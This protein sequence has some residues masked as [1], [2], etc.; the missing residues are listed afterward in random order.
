MDGDIVL[1]AEA[2]VEPDQLAHFIGDGHE[3]H[4]LYTF[5]LGSYLF[6]ALSRESGAPVKKPWELLPDKPEVGQWVNFRRNLDELDLERT[7]DRE[8][9][10][11]YT[12]FAP[13]PDMRI[14]ERGI[15]RRL[16]P[17]L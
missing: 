7:S 14:C 15:R 9:Q 11:V 8:R 5:L 13:D 2:D 16:A 3:M 12:A 10:D 4:M 6:L 17:M 1:L